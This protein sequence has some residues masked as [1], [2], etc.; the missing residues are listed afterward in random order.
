MKVAAFN[1]FAK[2]L[3]RFDNP[4]DG[5][6]LAEFSGLV[7]AI[8]LQ[9]HGIDLSYAP[10]LDLDFGLSEVI[11]DRSYG[12]LTQDVVALA[13][14]S[15]RGM[16]RG[17]MAAVGKHFPGH[18]GVA[19]DTHGEIA[20]DPRAFS[21]LWDADIYPFRMLIQQGLDAIMPAH[22]IY[23]QV[24]PL[25]AGFSSYWLKDILRKQLGFQGLIITDDLDMAGSH[26]VGSLADKL[27][28][29]AQAGCDLSLICNHF[30]AM[31]E[32]LSL[33]EIFIHFPAQSHQKLYGRFTNNLPEEL[34][35]QLPT[36]S[37]KLN[38]LTGASS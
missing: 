32:A 34:Q 37:A 36:Y 6:A 38:A 12:S 8:E 10:V 29:A 4:S 1:A 27:K 24:S 18:G 21:Y 35:Q 25:P 9:S 31:N 26:A 15:M 22:V 19:A 13:G 2:V 7:M 23:S 30:S 33:S 14:A 17:G 20:I 16:H 5:L 3:Q 11:G 28:A